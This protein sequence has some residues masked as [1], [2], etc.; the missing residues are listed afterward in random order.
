MIIGA[1]SHPCRRFLVWRAMRKEKLQFFWHMTMRR[2]YIKN[3]VKSRCLSPLYK[4]KAVCVKLTPFFFK[5]SPHIYIKEYID[6]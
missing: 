6:K 3:T 1:S 4:Q 5:K 2:R